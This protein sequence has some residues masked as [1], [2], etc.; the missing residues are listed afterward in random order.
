[1]RGVL[2]PLHGVA[3]RQDLPL[4]FEYALTGAVCAMAISFLGLA[5]LWRTP[6]FRGAATGRPLP[7]YL[8]EFMDA[9]EFRW[10]MRVL[11]LLIVGFTAFAAIV[12]PDL[13]TNPT[14]DLIYVVFWIGMVPLSMLLGPVWRLLNPLRTIHLLIYKA[15]G[16]DPNDP[17][18]R[19]PDW[20]GYW[21]GALGLFSFVWLELCAPDRDTLGTMRTYF[22]LYA[23]IN[24]LG[25][26]AFGTA[27]FLRCDG[28]EVFSS[29]IGRMSPFGRRTDGVIVVRNPLENLDTFPMAPGLVGLV[30]VM[31]GST[32]FDSFTASRWWIH[33]TYNSSLSVT[34][35]STIAL[36]LSVGAVMAAFCLAAWATGAVSGQGASGMATT[37]GHSLVPIAVGYLIAHYFSLLVFGGQQAFIR[38]SDPL[39]NGSNWFGTGHLFV[40]YSVLTPGAIAVVQVVSIV[41]G[42]VLGVFSAHDRAVRVFGGRRALVGQLPMMALMI[43]YTIGGL[44]LLFSA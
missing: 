39:V 30:G 27:W 36:L 23:G 5:F 4:P 7:G 1:V 41:T 3:S 20:V 6:R 19:L 29:A 12:G 40:N 34:E 10:F 42:H 37:F 25:A 2:L 17:P 38:S 43:G 32:A 18:L 22:A 35:L 31:L 9:P 44:S 26:L 15:V 11:G 14:G 21:P 24:L 13:A 28:F 8:S 33:K 16:L